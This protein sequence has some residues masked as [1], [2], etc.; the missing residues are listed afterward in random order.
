VDELEAVIDDG[1]LLE[2]DLL[3][4]EVG[5]KEDKEERPDD[6]DDVAPGG[7]EEDTPEDDVMNDELEEAV[8][9][10]ARARDAL[11]LE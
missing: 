4:E 3:V 1:T 2:V 6:V 9:M 8:I 5:R 11:A 7:P 10:K